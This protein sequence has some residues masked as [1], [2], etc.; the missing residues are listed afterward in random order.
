MNNTCLLGANDIVFCRL[1]DKAKC[2]IWT[3][4]WNTLGL[5]SMDEYFRKYMER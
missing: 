4:C 3:R 2:F 5:V 1:T